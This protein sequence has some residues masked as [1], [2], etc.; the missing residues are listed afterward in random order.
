LPFLITELGG[1]G[2]IVALDFSAEM[3]LQAQAKNFPPIV[4]FAQAD[5]L[6]IPLTDS[7]VDVAICNSAFPHFN[8]KVKALKEIAR[9]LRNNGRLVICHTMSREM[10]NRLHQSVG[11]VIAN[12]LLPDESQLR[13]LTKQAGL[14]VTRFEDNPERYLVIAEKSAR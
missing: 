2:K 7:S 10:V 5:V 1:E 13:A 12:D 9:V 8:D 4:G 11:G 3:L 6:A 14:N